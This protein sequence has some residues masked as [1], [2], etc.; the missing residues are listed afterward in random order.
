M[1]AY[2]PSLR[3]GVSFENVLLPPPIPEATKLTVT[4]RQASL[5][6]VL[7]WITQLIGQSDK[8]LQEC[9]H[10]AGLVAA[11]RVGGG[12]SYCTISI[13]L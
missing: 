2:P 10:P 5:Q 12:H 7:C 6:T 13:A 1:Q 8:F 11:D 9:L 3:P 4:F